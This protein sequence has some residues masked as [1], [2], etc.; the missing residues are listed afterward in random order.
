MKG[1]LFIEKQIYILKKCKT[2][3]FHTKYNND[4][5]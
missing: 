3:A 5:H 2:Y 1:M 4:P